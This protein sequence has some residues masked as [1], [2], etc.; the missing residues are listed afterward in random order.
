MFIILDYIKRLITLQ[1]RL[2]DAGYVVEAQELEC[3]K[4]AKILQMFGSKT[5]QQKDDQLMVNIKDEPINTDNNID[6][7]ME[8]DENVD[9]RSMIEKHMNDL[10]T[11]LKNHEEKT[12]ESSIP[13]VVATKTSCALRSAIIHNALQRSTSKKCIHC[14]NNLRYIKFLRKKLVYYITQAEMKEK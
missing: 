9:Q 10:H 2:I 13:S 12:K 8:N 7:N 6:N 4:S 5:E 14:R 3:Y 1:L 11:L